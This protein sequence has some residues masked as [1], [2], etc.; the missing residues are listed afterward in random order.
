M[1]ELLN[2][3]G[4]LFIAVFTA[5]TVSVSPVIPMSISTPT[6]TPTPTLIISPSNIPTPTPSD[7]PTRTPINIIQ[8]YAEYRYHD[9]ND[10]T[11]LEA[12]IML[13]IP[14]NG[15]MVEGYIRGTCNGTINGTYDGNE[16][17]EGIMNG[18]CIITAIAFHAE[19]IWSGKIDKIEKSLILHYQGE[20]GG[21]SK[22][23]EITMTY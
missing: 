16:K 4:H 3:I 18:N 15:G 11:R 20:G 10:V 17:L 19:G 9:Y 12:K 23:G 22:S 2:S 1:I 5:F 7:M 14:E 21:F 6:P 8:A 13:K